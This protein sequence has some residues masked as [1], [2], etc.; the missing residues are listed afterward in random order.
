MNEYEK[1]GTYVADT[2][3]DGVLFE[4][5]DLMHGNG[6][7]S[8][9]NEEPAIEN[10]MENS[11]NASQPEY[12]DTDITAPPTQQND[13][14]T[15]SVTEKGIEESPDMQ[16]DYDDDTDVDGAEVVPEENSAPDYQ[17][18]EENDE[19]GA[20]DPK[21]VQSQEDIEGE[22]GNRN[23]TEK[24]AADEDASPN[25]GTTETDQTISSGITA[26]A[27]LGG[28]TDDIHNDG[29]DVT[30]AEMPETAD[31]PPDV[32]QTDSDTEDLKGESLDTQKGE[33]IYNPGG[34]GNETIDE[35]AP[36]AGCSPPNRL[37][38]VL[39]QWTTALL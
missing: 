9:H 26:G 23:D 5:H 27:L 4:N 2:M 22:D 1:T 38:E 31:H 30:E 11:E 6:L 16:S 3:E 15:E 36:D 28:N 24:Q 19:E 10:E 12:T 32:Q 39:H 25:D 14:L 21:G 18:R 17:Q 33:N 13:Q 8:L 35:Q 29:N 7:F 34:G 37:V 20:G